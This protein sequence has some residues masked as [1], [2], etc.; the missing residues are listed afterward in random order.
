MALLASPPFR[1]PP[2][3][4][5]RSRGPPAVILV[6]P[7]PPRQQPAPF[8]PLPGPALPASSRAGAALR[9]LL[10]PLAA[11][12]VGWPLPRKAGRAGARLEAA[13]V[14]KPREVLQQEPVEGAGRSVRVKY[15]KALVGCC[16]KPD[17]ERGAWLF[18]YAST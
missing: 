8:L 9:P 15:A 5:R 12:A 14:Q 4:G 16:S 2:V 13:G 1:P 18:I 11:L 10:R 6:Q 3:R 7:L 17:G